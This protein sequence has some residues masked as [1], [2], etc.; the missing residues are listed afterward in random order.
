M[1]GDTDTQGPTTP[2]ADPLDSLEPTAQDSS[3]D[4]A[5][6]LVDDVSG[7]FDWLPDFWGVAGPEW[8]FIA[9]LVVLAVVADATTRFVTRMGLRRLAKRESFELDADDVKRFARP[10]GLL[11]GALVASAGLVVLGLDQEGSDSERVGVALR[12]AADVI[13]AVGGIWASYRAVDLICGHLAWRAARS[14]NRFDDVLVPL[15]R[16][17]LKIIVTVV[18]I[19]FLATHWVEDLWGVIAGL[20][21]GSLAIGFAARDSIENLFGTFTVLID[22]PFEIGDWIVVDGIEGTVEEV[23]FRSTR[24]RT[25]YDSLYTVPNRHFISGQ[26]D[27]YGRRRKRRIKTFLSL[28]YDTPPERIDA[29]CEGVRQLVRR[30]PYTV[31][32]GFHVYF[33]QMGAH[34][35]DVLLYVFVETPDWATEMRE[36]HR[37]FADVLRLA[38]ELDVEFA[39]P[40]STVQLAG[41]I[42]MHEGAEEAGPEGAAAEAGRADASA[43]RAVA[44]RIVDDLLGPAGTPPPP[45]AS[46]D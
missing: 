9:V 24:I 35:L 29:F 4:P 11:V 7:L 18:A 43:G 19:A 8:G 21:I 2:G 20:S 6:G 32:E 27:N 34:S 37:L 3:T 12:F 40:T 16:R 44:D 17:S 10:V 14:A 45:P 41:G 36:K 46:A 39:F 23:G 26:V 15:L 13:V 22:K 30:H 25:F 5:G 42:E 28:T 38:K 33:T 31:K 1:Q